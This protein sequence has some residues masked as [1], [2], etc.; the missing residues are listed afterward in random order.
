[1]LQVGSQVFQ[2]PTQSQREITIVQYT[3]WLVGGLRGSW[4]LASAHALHLPT[5]RC[6]SIRLKSWGLGLMPKECLAKV[7]ALCKAMPQVFGVWSSVLAKHPKGSEVVHKVLAMN[8][9]GH[10][11]RS[12]FTRCL[13]YLNKRSL[14]TWS[15]SQAL[16]VM[17]MWEWRKSRV[18][19]RIINSGS[20]KFNS[21]K[22]LLYGEQS[23]G[24]DG[25]WGWVLIYH[26]GV[27][28]Q[29]PIFP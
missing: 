29:I 6:L 23:W 22:W 26:G 16:W 11:L 15:R 9:V 21:M 25:N 3:S 13:N 12:W 8:W 27:Y 18:H 1:V 19:T 2:N 28:D 10:V 5:A 24:Y 17:G 14:Y 4:T 7:W 20:E